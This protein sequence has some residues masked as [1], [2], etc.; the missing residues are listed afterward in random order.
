MSQITRIRTILIALV[1]AAL[2]FTSA[3]CD[4]MA[5][6]TLIAREGKG[7]LERVGSQLVLHI[8]GSPAEMG[9]QQG[10]LLR[11]HIKAML[12]NIRNA[13]KD[14]L[15][16]AADLSNLMFDSVWSQEVKYIPARYVEEMRAVAD[17]A[18]VDF[19]ILRRANTIPEFFHCSGFAVFGKAT[20]DGTLYHGRILDYGVEVG[21]QDHP[22]VIIAEPDGYC[23]FVNVSY[24][25][26]IGSVTGMNL[27]QLAFGE[28]G[29]GGQGKWDGT[30]MSFLM[31]RGL[32]E[33][34]TLDQA[35]AIFSDSKRTCEYYYVISDA[36]IPGAVGV[37]AT[38]E[39]IE[40]VGPNEAKG[41]LNVPIQDVVALSRGSVT[42]C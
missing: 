38:P 41:P 1:L 4:T 24:A 34:K 15:G 30:P 27:N 19:N 22:V 26:F 33:A 20:T 8:K 32:E 13:S 3:A 9:H 37:S 5:K 18:G 42:H 28:M 29:G 11:D 25:G 23:P 21:L 12:E 14:S 7:Y 35:K 2:C 39:H 40:F 17:G 16:A 10:V 36:K 6:R 31:R